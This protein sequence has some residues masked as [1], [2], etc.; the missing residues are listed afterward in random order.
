MSY[1]RSQPYEEK[2]FQR[3]SH[4]DSWISANFFVEQTARPDIVETE[5]A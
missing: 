1:L 5:I 3:C 2:D 4:R